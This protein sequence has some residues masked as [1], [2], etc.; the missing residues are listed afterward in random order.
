M[1]VVARCN[2]REFYLTTPQDFERVLA[3]LRGM[4]QT[5]DVTLYTNTLM[6]NHVHLLLQAPKADALGR[7]FRRFRTETA[8]V[9]HRVR[10]RRGHFWGLRY[11]TWLVEEDT[12]TLAALR[13]LDRNPVRAW[14]IEDPATY[15]WSSC[16]TYAWRRDN[17]LIVYHPSYLT[18]SPSPKVRQRHYRVLL[19]PTAD[20]RADARD[21]RWTTHR[22][23]G[24]PSFMARYR[25][26]R[27]RR[28]TSAM[29]L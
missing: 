18:L 26:R 7:P 27:G 8:K 4:L 6:G 16:A 28:K 17:P 11:H 3:T 25:A 22:A 19:A 24:S 20:P 9:F 13:Y 15:P 5:S 23:V 29:P 1:H 12:Y 10:L 21:P 14:L 2:N